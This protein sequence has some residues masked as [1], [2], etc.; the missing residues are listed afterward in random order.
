MD[1][2]TGLVESIAGT[3]EPGYSGDGGDAIEAKFNQP[4]DLEFGPDGLLYVADRFNN[5]VRAI[6][7]ESNVVETVVGNGEH[8]AQPTNCYE[9]D[10]NVALLDLQLSEPFGLAFD[11]AGDLYIAD[12]NNSRIVKVTR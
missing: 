11:P 3:G 4:M 10:D 8:C 12:A 1:L 5:V 9:Q 6:D 7:L 2:E